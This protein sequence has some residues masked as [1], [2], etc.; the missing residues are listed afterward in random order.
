MGVDLNSNKTRTTQTRTGSMKTS[1]YLAAIGGIPCLFNLPAANA[2]L[3]PIAPIVGNFRDVTP[4]DSEFVDAYITKD[5]PPSFVTFNLLASADVTVGAKSL[6]EASFHVNNVAL[7]GNDGLIGSICVQLLDGCPNELHLPLSPGE[8]ALEVFSHGNRTLSPPRADPFDP[9]W[10]QPDFRAYIQ[11]F[12]N[13]KPTLFSLLGSASLD[14][15]HGLGEEGK[16]AAGKLEVG[17]Q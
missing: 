13:P 10:D 6:D 17:R 9:R 8:Y 12:Q 16:A 11:Q 3:G 15:W 4:P 1:K 7:F 5:S 2:V 14:L